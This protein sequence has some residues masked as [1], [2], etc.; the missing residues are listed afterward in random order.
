MVQRGF[1]LLIAAEN[2]PLSDSGGL[3]RLCPEV[4]FLETTLLD[5]GRITGIQRCGDKF[6]KLLNTENREM[7][8]DHKIRYA[9]GVMV[10]P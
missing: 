4:G 3:R 7:D 6:T 8:R 10:P 9:F 5:C 1:L 2:E